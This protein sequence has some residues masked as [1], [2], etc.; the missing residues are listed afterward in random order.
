MSLIKALFINM[1]KVVP[2]F[3]M[4]PEL[5]NKLHSN[6]GKL[7]LYVKSSGTKLTKKQQ[8]YIMDQ[9]KQLDL[10]EKSM[11]PPTPKGPKA[12]VIDLS[13]KLPEDAPYSEKNPTG[14][15][16]TE[17]EREGIM[18][19]L[20]IN[21]NL[22]S[23]TINLLKGKTDPKDMQ[24]ELKKIIGR[25]GT[26]ADYSDDEIKAILN[27]I[28]DETKSEIKSLKTAEE[29]ID[30]GD[31]DPSGMKDG[32]R[33]GYSIGA[34][35]KAYRGIK[36]LMDKVNKRFGK[37][38][39]KTA[40]E[41][42]RPEKAKLKEMF[43]DFNKRFKEKTTNTEITLPSGIKGIIDTTYEPKIKKFEGMSKIILSPEE[44]IKLSKK[45]KLEGIESL[46]SGE[47]VALSRGAGKG[48]MVNQ[49][50]K[51]FIREKIKDRPNPI[52]ED[53]K[54]IIE[55]FDSM[56]DEEPVEMSMSDLIE[57]RSQNP[58]GQGRFTKAE[59]IIARLENT[60]QNAKNN[61]DETS[62]YVLENF[63][64][65][66]KELKNKPELANNKNVWKE[67]GMTG[68][69]E[70]QRFKIYDDGTVDFETLKP[71]HQFKL[72]DDITKHAT[73]GRVGFSAG[74]I[75]KVR[76]ALLKMF[77]GAAATG[78]AV[79]TGLGGL[80]KGGEKAKDVVKTAETVKTA[81]NTPP[82][83]VFDLIKIIKAKGKDITK[84]AGTIERETVTSYRGVELYET[85]NGVVIRAEGKTPYEGGKEIQLSLNKTT[86]V[87]DEGKKT[88][89]QVSKV[90]YEEATVR[91]DPEGKMKDVDFYVDETD[92]AELK[93]IVDEEKGF[94]SGGLAY[95]L[96]E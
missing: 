5:A 51:I 11:T 36:A 22:V 76:R 89:K 8:D 12:E 72:R 28:E 40:E 81:A 45:E 59:A 50:G 84:Q 4:T 38:T 52:K 6:L 43:D 32:G 19:S 79:K 60:I 91:P 95:M 39:I 44:A 1:G 78:V 66:I 25:K 92:H 16:P 63:P 61:P 53:E 9:T 37:G 42:D 41:I 58:A 54:A 35:V 85:P 3:K 87:V 33:I 71:T 69:P 83:Y 30:E 67:L 55:E 49:N 94:K 10:Y 14:W 68:L 15:M 7:M 80:L 82:N 57:Y 20:D 13:K 47:K 65:M 73:G 2:Y 46:L 64:N 77:G 31:F 29:I 62:D 70:N 56:F 90:E 18:A 21:E 74:G 24:S 27:G 86:D 93:R 17:K 48:L 23:D 26:Y 96:G 88:Q 75:D 34:G